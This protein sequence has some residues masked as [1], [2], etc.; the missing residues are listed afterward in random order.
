MGRLTRIPDGGQWCVRCRQVRAPGGLVDDG[1][2]PRAVL[3]LGPLGGRAPL[4]HA[5]A[6][7]GLITTPPPPYRGR[8]YDYRL[9]CNGPFELHSFFAVPLFSRGSGS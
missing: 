5:T 2:V 7:M 4:G 9:I 6:G 8:Q 1:D 3:L